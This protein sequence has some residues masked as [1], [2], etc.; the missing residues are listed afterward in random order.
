MPKSTKILKNET[1]INDRSWIAA[2]VIVKSYKIH[3]ALQ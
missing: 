2:A 1:N 3:C